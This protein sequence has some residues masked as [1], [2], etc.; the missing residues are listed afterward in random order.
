MVSEISQGFSYKVSSIGEDY[1]FY[2][3]DTVSGRL[4]AEE[5]INLVAATGIRLV[6]NIIYPNPIGLE[7]W[8]R[9]E[10]V[11]KTWKQVWDE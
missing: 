1:A 5:L 3:T 11:A 8:D 9:T 6:I 10:E 4:Y 7:H 2:L